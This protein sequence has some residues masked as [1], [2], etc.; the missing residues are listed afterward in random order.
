M[1]DSE[2]DKNRI[3]FSISAKCRST[4]ITH[5]VINNL[6]E[7]PEFILVLLL[8]ISVTVTTMVYNGYVTTCDFISAFPATVVRLF[9]K[10]YIFLSLLLKI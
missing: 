8:H 3:F 2:R 5:M 6:H 4:F 1:S 7:E 10:S 9:K